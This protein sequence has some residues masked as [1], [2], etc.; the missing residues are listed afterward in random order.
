MSEPERSG[1]S[2]WCSLNSNNVPNPAPQPIYASHENL[3][4]ISGGSPYLMPSTRAANMVNRLCRGD[5][6][7]TRPPFYLISIEFPDAE[8][9]SAF[10][11][12]NVSGAFYYNSYPSFNSSSIIVAIA[13]TIYQ[14][15][16]SGRIG[17][18]SILAKGNNPRLMHTW[19]A[20]GYNY[21]F[22]QNGEQNCIVWDGI[23]PA[24]RADPT[25]QQTPIGG[26][27]AFIWGRMAVTS[28]D[29]T[30]QLA[31]S[32]I[33]YST[34]LTTPSDINSYTDTAYWS[35]GGSFGTAL[36]VGD[37]QGLA[38]MPYLDTGTGQN[39]LVVLGTEGATC[40]DF[41]TLRDQWTSQQVQRICLI[42]MGCCSTH[43]LCTLNGDLLYKSPEGIRS[44]KN[45]R[46]EFDRG[47]NQTPLSYDVE[48]WLK[49][50]NQALLQFS[51]QIAWNNLLISTVMPMMAA[52]ASAV[53]GYHR[54]H[55][56]LIVMDCNPQ[57]VTQNN[58][59][60]VWQGLWTGPRTTALVQGIDQGVSRSFA[61][62]FDTDG[63]NRLYE[64][65]TSGQ[66]DIIS[67][68][69]RQ[70]II[71]LYDT[72]M[73]WGQNSDTF[74]HK[75]LTG[76]NIE[77]SDIRE[78]VDLSIKYKPDNCPCFVPYKAI[79]IGCACQTPDPK[80]GCQITQQPGWFRQD[81]G[82]PDPTAVNGFEGIAPIF[83]S[84]QYR[85]KMTGSARVDRFGIT[86][87]QKE[88]SNKESITTGGTVATTQNCLINGCCPAT[89][90][91]EYVLQ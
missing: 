25:K 38:A 85:I 60:P 82:T 83:R 86:M 46:L 16:L 43:S 23:N 81:F 14:I 51:N 21:L 56:G 65:G 11:T 42:G 45:S 59:V 5:E 8:T 52:P 28:A 68:G 27:M 37:I 69:N 78:Q 24:F 89:E 32:D 91:F 7:K 47:Y 77:I 29:G 10:E 22:I 13:G 84:A 50:E 70:R 18:V 75:R 33:A 12:G 80:T 67:G 76:T 35:G 64:F 71:S 73:A 90:E 1:M 54:Y 41:S 79:T 40:F 55:R 66:D 6:N 88:Q 34:N 72:P 49:Q 26:P 48:K 57:S 3:V 39:E 62:S 30:N 36:F 17:F 58:A 44:Y 53:N 63:V 9:Q 61:F 4:G 87:I 19:F 74:T 20:Q 31:V 15:Q 2:G